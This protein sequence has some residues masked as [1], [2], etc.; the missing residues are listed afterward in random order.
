MGFW[1]GFWAGEELRWD[2]VGVL[3]TTIWRAAFYVGFRTY[4]ERDEYLVLL[5]R[6][7]C[8]E[9]QEVELEITAHHMTCTARYA[10]S[11][12]TLGLSAEHFP[13]S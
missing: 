10:T 13:I 8:P 2:E 3:S 11:T 4:H 7:H 6:E 12:M 9:S 5:C 1:P